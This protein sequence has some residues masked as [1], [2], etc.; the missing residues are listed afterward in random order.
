MRLLAAFLLLASPA[1]AVTATGLSSFDAIEE[2]RVKFSPGTRTFQPDDFANVVDRG[3]GVFR[4]HNRFTA[5]WWDGDRDTQNRDRQRAEVRGLG[6]H[7]HDGETFLYS[8]T[9]RLNENFHGTAG[10][11]HL[12][13]LKS[14][15]GDSAMPLVTLS[16]RGDKAVVEANPDGPKIVA[17][18]FPWQ[19]G[20]WQRVQI[21][22]ATSTRA[23]HG[24]LSVSVN[25]DAFA[26][27]GG[28]ALARPQ[29][30]AYRPKWG[31]YRRAAA[32]ASLGDDYVEHKDVSA[33][34]L[35]APAD[36]GTDNVALEIQARGHA[37]RES[38]ASALAWLQGRPASPAR[39]FALGSIAALWAETDPRAAMTWADALPRGAVRT[40]ATERIFSRW[41]DEDVTTAAQWL[42]AHAPKP[43][44]DRLVWLFTTDTTYRY[45][46]R[47]IALDALPRIEN[48]DLRVQAF[49]HVLEIWARTERDA[50]VA[51]AQA[52]PALN[53]EQKAA[54]IGKLAP[55]PATKA[56]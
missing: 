28:I 12:F 49:D 5:E 42:H 10:F 26:G 51:F 16:I 46:Q 55:R 52:S 38:P 14:T 47:K 34:K 50:A 30:N 37:Q 32:S 6:P 33:E 17:R 39:D 54:V 45:G 24:E 23:P 1:L 44:L 4:M 36:G 8:F 56:P 35:P 48:P 21:K 22:I 11:C 19:P 9:W 43:D 29:A 2:P 27:K 18:E 31:L 41:A 40:D 20:V 15:D 3:A 13:Q 7:Q 53:A 25:G